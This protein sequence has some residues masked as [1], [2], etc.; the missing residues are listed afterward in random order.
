[1]KLGTIL[2]NKCYCAIVESKKSNN[3]NRL[4]VHT[5][6]FDK[7]YHNTTIDKRP[8]NQVYF[9]DQQSDLFDSKQSEVFK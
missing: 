7:S 8:I 5:Q 3:N 4:S 2:C 6:E 1:M 9:L